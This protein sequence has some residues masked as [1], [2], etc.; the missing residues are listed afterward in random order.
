MK[1]RIRESLKEHVHT[2]GKKQIAFSYLQILAGCLTG[3]AAY[4]A[5][6]IPIQFCLGKRF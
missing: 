1:L 4:P 5:F 2:L 6:L 3:A